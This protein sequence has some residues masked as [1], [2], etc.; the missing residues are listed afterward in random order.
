[1]LGVLCDLAVDPSVDIAFAPSKMF[2]YSVRLQTPF[3]PLI[4]DSALGNGEDFRDLTGRHHPVR[5]A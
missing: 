1:L 5:A 4:P 2:S 3:P